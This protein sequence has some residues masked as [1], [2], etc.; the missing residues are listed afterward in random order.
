MPMKKA[1]QILSKE[2]QVILNAINTPWPTRYLIPRS[3]NQCWK[4]SP[5]QK[6]ENLI[7]KF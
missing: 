6:G 2:H 7:K 5:K 3:K 1:T 4:N